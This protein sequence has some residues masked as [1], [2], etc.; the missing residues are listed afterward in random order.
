MVFDNAGEEE[1]LQIWRIEEFAPVAYPATEQGRFH[2]GDSY[3]VLNT[4]D[5][6]GKLSW[7]LHFWLGNQ[8]S[9]DEAGAAAMLS[10]DLDNQLGGVPVQYRET[11]GN[12]SSK[13]LSYF[14]KGLKYLPGGV[15]SGF[16]HYDPEDVEQRM[17][18]VKGKRNIRVSEV[19][20][21][22][23]SMNKSDCFILDGGKGNQILVFMPPGAR[24]MEKFRA[25]QVANEIRDEDHAGNSEVE[26][27]DEFSDNLGKFFD[28]LGSGSADEIPDEDDID[29]ESADLAAKTEVK[30]CVVEGGEIVD[31]LY[32]PLSQTALDTQKIFVLYGGKSEI[33]VWVG[34]GYEGNG[35][36]WS[37]SFLQTAP[38]SSKI[39][40]VAEGLETAL[41]KQYFSA[42]DESSEDAFVESKIAEWK[43][44]DLHTEN[45]SRILKAA[46]TAPGFLPDDGSGEKTIFRVENMELVPVETEN[47]LFGGDSYVIQYQYPAGAIVYFWQGLKSSQDERASSAIHAADLDNN[48]L[49]GQAIQV[50]VVQGEEPRHFLNMFN[51][52]L[53]I[54]TGGKASG[55]K[56]VDDRDEYDEDGTRLFRV[57]SLSADARDARAVQVEETFSSLASDDV[58]ILETK[59]QCWLWKGKE[60][61]SEEVEAARGFLKVLCPDRDVQDVEEGDEGDEMVEALGGR[62]DYSTPHLKI[63]LPPR[64]FHLRKL[65]SGKTRAIEI[66]NFTKQDLVSDDV[67]IL[68]TGREIF[69]WVGEEAD[70][71]EKEAAMKMAVEY[72]DADPSYRTPDNTVVIQCRQNQ[73]PDSFNAFFNPV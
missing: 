16:K 66:F 4:R 36:I 24:K 22:V 67:M 31:T 25:I 7:T 10:V 60:S 64:L 51:G 42:W 32:Q 61:S 56:N 43:V 54:F 19:D 1:G 50:R 9:Q 46:G 15:Q 20:V 39:L 37:E 70:S 14:P 71:D 41:F 5:N 2:T 57:R 8:T 65:N 59:Q 28:L 6:G 48:Q 12:E 33:Y 29:D 34:K 38:K 21:S 44:E 40:K 35:K 27:V 73:E 18:K 52:N 58:F 72:L 68:D 47:F 30:L 26:V 69:V 23:S 55:F 45:R 62:Q 13:F 3:I 17:F 49:Q 63:S 11:E 53:V